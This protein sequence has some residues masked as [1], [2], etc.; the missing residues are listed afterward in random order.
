ML[1]RLLCPAIVAV[2]LLQQATHAESIPTIRYDI[3]AETYAEGFEIPW[4]L[5]FLPDGRLLVTERQGTIRIVSPDGSVSEPIDGVPPVRARGQGG[6]M[7][8]V[9]HPDF[10]NNQ[11]VYLSYSEPG[12]GDG[13]D[14]IGYTVIDRARLTGLA[15][16]DLERVYEVDAEFYSRRGHHFGSRIVFDADGFLYFTI[17]DRGQRPLAQSVE[18]PNGKVHRLHDDGRIPADNPFAEQ[19]GAITSIW[20]YG[21]R[22]PQG[23]AV[24]PAT[25]EIYTTEHGPRG[26]DEL[27]RIQKGVNYGWPA[28]TYGINYDGTPITEAM[29]ADGMEQ[30][31]LFWN[32]SIA[33][34]GID[35][36]DGDQFPKWKNHLL[37]TALAFQQ[38]RRVHI[39][40][41]R[42]IHQEIIFEPGSRFRDVETGPGGLIYVALEEPGRIVRLS[43]AD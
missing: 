24:H 43:P 30:P 38:L 32:P 23:M 37:V 16:T 19:P 10:A 28:I 20:S 33:P 6:L 13:D 2:A 17:G 29:T 5:E 26:G 40:Q 11:L 3:V 9:L 22:N 18:T 8:I 31:I 12:V 35:F 42:V 4:A 39:E 34:C 21:H 7:D 41:G 36:Y 1:R 27:N 25:G 15:L 14:T